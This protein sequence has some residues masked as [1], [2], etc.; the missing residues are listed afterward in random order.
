M[1]WRRKA[2]HLC[3][4]AL[5]N[6]TLEHMQVLERQARD[7][8]FDVCWL[9]LGHQPGIAEAVE[10]YAGR[11]PTPVHTEE[12][13][14]QHVAKHRPVSVWL[15]TPYP[16]HYPEW[17]WR[18]AEDFPLAYTPYGAT[19]PATVWE[20]GAYGLD[21]FRRCTWLV[22]S[23]A[24]LRDG[25]IAH[26][27]PPERIVLGGDK[28]YF[29]IRRRR[30][31]PVE[32][33]DLLWAPHWIEDMFGKGSLATWRETA[34]VLLDYASRHPETSLVVRPHPFLEKAIE[35]APDDDVDATAYRRLLALPNVQR[36]DRSLAEDVLGSDALISEGMSVLVYFATLGRPIGMLQGTLTEVADVYLEILAA[37]DALP[38]PEATLA[39]L[40]RLPE[41][42]ADPALA[43]LME[44]LLPA[45]DR[46]PIA[47]WNEQRRARRARG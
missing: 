27:V 4:T 32:R 11:R 38:T 20:E 12:A 29:E 9:D 16:E 21:T 1:W 24:D 23:D 47:I 36:S 15:H 43:T 41:A 30:D 42:S 44:R 8:G 14:R 35:E 28:M 45:Y 22:A 2:E 37:C 18:A 26:G 13:L 3:L 10:T 6:S 7:E 34:P 17:F 5:P 39:W 33:R 46:S 31:E 19:I 40:E 25:W